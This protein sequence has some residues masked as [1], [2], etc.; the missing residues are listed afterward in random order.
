MKYGYLNDLGTFVTV[1]KCMGARKERISVE[2]A[3]SVG[4]FMVPPTPA[5]TLCKVLFLF[6]SQ[7]GYLWRIKI[8]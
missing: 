8:L 4:V 1:R 6:C 7:R 3:L 5:V 2:N